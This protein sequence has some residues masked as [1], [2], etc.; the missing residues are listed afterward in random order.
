DAH[1]SVGQSK[2]EFL[3]LGVAR[4]PAALPGNARSYMQ[5]TIAQ[6]EPCQRLPPHA[7]KQGTVRYTPRHESQI[8]ALQ[9][10]FKLRLSEIARFRRGMAMLPHRASRVNAGPSALPCAI[11]EVEVFDIGGIVDLIKV[12]EL[13]EARGIEERTAAARVEHP[14]TVFA[15]Q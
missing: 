10:L 8:I 6:E 11:A 1:G 12:S 14:G 7:P 13:C 9:D 3:A 15:R 4:R 5:R 2:E